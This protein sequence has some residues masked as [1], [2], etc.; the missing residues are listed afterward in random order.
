MHD[1]PLARWLGVALLMALAVLFGS[2]HIAARLAFDHGLT[3]TTAVMARSG[4]TALAVLLLL[5][6]L[7]VPL[8]MPG[9]TWKRGL[10]IGAIL[11]MQSYCLYS[12]VARIPAALALLIFNLHPM[13]LTLL[14]WATGGGRPD[15]RALGAMP[16]ALLGLALVL[17]LQG[18]AS[19]SGRWSEIGA[20]VGFAFT[21]A[22]SFAT[23][24]YLSAR[25]LKGVDGRLRSCVTMATVA[26]LALV[27]G[28]ATGTLALPADAQAWTGLALLTLLYGIAITSLFMLVP[29]LS[30]ASDMAALNFEPI[31]VIGIAWVTLGQA[32]APLQIAG[33]L[34]V[35]ASIVAL[36]SGGK[37]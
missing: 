26:V 16:V 14:T 34:I 1:R 6:A 37:R 29:R 10:A 28:V 23:A 5:L 2:N 25:W 30:A 15:A 33:A 27:A 13:L 31:A 19:V 21:A 4:V 20:G 3:V 32:L 17:D 12:S 24:M 11:S 35:V 18:G 22:L 7:R 36:G 9:A 8:A